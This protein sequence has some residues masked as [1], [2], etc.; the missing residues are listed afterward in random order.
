MEA[1]GRY[2]LLTSRPWLGLREVDRRDEASVGWRKLDA[3]SDQI[4]FGGRRLAAENQQQA[5]A[6]RHK[7]GA[8]EQ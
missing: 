1:V 2:R 5:D 8:G 7:Y 3:G 4:A 6:E